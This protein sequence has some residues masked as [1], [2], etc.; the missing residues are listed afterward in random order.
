VIDTKWAREFAQEWIA[1]WNAHDLERILSHYVDDFEMRS[2]LIAE[3]MGVPSGMLK[4]KAAIRPYWERALSSARPPCF[5][6]LDVLIGA[7]A[8]AL[9]YWSVARGKYVIE[10]LTFNEQREVV[11][12]AAFYSEPAR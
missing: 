11:S 4:G 10:V 5:E 8:I 3:G 1:A 6:L 12:G 7:H 2:P 9:H